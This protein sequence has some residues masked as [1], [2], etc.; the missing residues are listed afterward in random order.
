LSDWADREFNGDDFRDEDLTQLRTERVVFNECDF[1]GANLGESEHVASAF[2][3]CTFRRT[4]LW[5]SSFSQ[6]S[7]L[8]SVFSECRLRPITL[9]EVDFTLA[10]LGGCDLREVD[11]SGSRLRET[12][13]VE[14]DLRAAVFTGCDLRGA[15]T[16]GARFE[17]ADLRGAITDPSL[18]TTAKLAG[19]RI[20]VA[21]ALAYAAANGL[22]VRGE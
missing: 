13:L 18:W 15:R 12:G 17:K 2:R 19:A 8:G 11:F 9:V 22:D 7:V 3:N 1:S 20:D 21:Q 16:I 14:A 10:V 6:C 5:H 4:T